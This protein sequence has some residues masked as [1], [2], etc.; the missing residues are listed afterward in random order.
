[1]A[2]DRVALF[3]TFGGSV[4]KGAI[5]EDLAEV[6]AGKLNQTVKIKAEAKWSVSPLEIEEIQILDVEEFELRPNTKLFDD[7]R[8]SLGDY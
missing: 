5:T 6:I 3:R 4:Y 2:F 8:A 1:M 7:L